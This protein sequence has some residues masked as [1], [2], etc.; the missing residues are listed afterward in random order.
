MVS[1]PSFS[2]T[3]NWI[4]F[5]H[6]HLIFPFLASFKYF[7]VPSTCCSCVHVVL[8]WF[9]TSPLMGDAADA[10]LALEVYFWQSQFPESKVENLKIKLKLILRLNSVV[11]LIWIWCYC[12]KLITFDTPPPRQDA[13]CTNNRLE[14]AFQYCFG[15][16]RLV[17]LRNVFHVCHSCINRNR[18]SRNVSGIQSYLL[19][20]T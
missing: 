8:T 7:H 15:S 6:V 12:W 11:R 17:S 9:F 2:W 19:P 3:A 16:F 4:L 5:V 14:I 18:L 20:W 1:R 13:C 10:S